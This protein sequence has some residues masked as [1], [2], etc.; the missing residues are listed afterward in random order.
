[1]TETLTTFRGRCGS[2]GNA[3]DRN[4]GKTPRG[5]G[6]EIYI[7]RLYWHRLSGSNRWL[8]NNAGATRSLPRDGGGV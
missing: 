6:T 2:C 3:R 1:M 8:R 7:G 4:S 5:T